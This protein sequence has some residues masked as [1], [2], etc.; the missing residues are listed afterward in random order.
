MSP[1][2]A[3]YHPIIPGPKLKDE[4]EQGSSGMHISQSMPFQYCKGK[5]RIKIRVRTT[6]LQS[7]LKKYSF[8]TFFINL[9]YFV[10]L[11][12]LTHATDKVRLKYFID[13]MKLWQTQNS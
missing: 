2:Q 10:Q 12:F 13:I 8:P 9:F 6:F 7:G 4:H 5:I 11:N 3:E 1:F